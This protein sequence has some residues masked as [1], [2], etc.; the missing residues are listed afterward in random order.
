[1]IA[2]MRS[3]A[4]PATPIFRDL[5]EDVFWATNAL[6]AIIDSAAAQAA[7]PQPANPG[8]GRFTPTD[9]RTSWSAPE[10]PAGGAF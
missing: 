6:A 9:Q 4:A 2:P 7:V 1:M 8:E 3:S 5:A 10:G